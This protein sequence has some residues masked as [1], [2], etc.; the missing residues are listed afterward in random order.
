M[1]I[2][3]IKIAGEKIEEGDLVY[4]GDDGKIYKTV[5]TPVRAHE[6]HEVE[7]SQGG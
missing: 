6:S 4:I 1:W 5:T 2:E 7:T 3:N